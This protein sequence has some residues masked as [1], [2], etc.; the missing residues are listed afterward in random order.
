MMKEDLLSMRNNID[1]S[2]N[3]MK[4]LVIGNKERFIHLENFLSKLDNKDF[5]TKLIHDLDYIGR[6]FDLNLFKKNKLKKEFEKILDSYKPDIVLFDRISKITKI[7]ISKNIPI[8]ILLRGNYWKEVEYAL[9]TSTS[10]KNRLAIK[11]NQELVDYCFNN[12]KLILPISKYLENE[13]R[14]RYPNKKIKLFQ[15]DGRNPDEWNKVSSNKLKHPCV[16]LL[17]GFNVWGKTQELLVLKE[18]A[19]KLPNVTFY[20]AGDGMYRDKIIPKL[21]DEKN[22]FWLE[23][24]NYPNEVK[25][26]LSE[27]DVFM[28]LSGL[29]GLGQTIIEALLMKKP[30]IATNIG[31]IPELIINDETGLL[32]EP[33]NS[34]KIVKNILRVLNDQNFSEEIAGKGH[35]FVKNEFSWENIA[36]KFESILKE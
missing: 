9:E 34:E 10:Q 16:G 8:W 5:D 30:V 21:K 23:Q 17:Q 24:I 7:V 33:G 25:E 31:G 4:L 14:E 22:F 3:R 11:K 29:E 19:K 15:A 2:N 28:L 32:V 13:V 20:L 27:I 18:V 36:K 35:I 26:F 1:F 12:C 6:F